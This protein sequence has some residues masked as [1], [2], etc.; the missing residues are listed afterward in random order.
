MTMPLWSP[1]ANAK[2]TTQLGQFWQ[3]IEQQHQVSLPTYRALHQWTV[4]QKEAFWQAVMAFADIRYEGSP[5]PALVEHELFQHNQW[6]PEV[7]LN[8]AENLLWRRDEHPALIS[9]TENTGRVAYSYA[10]LYQAAAA[11][12]NAHLSAGVKPGDRVAAWLPNGPEAII[13]ALGAA[14]V[15]AVWSSCSPDFGYAG[16]VDRFGQIKPTVLIVTDGY[17]YSGRWQ[18]ISTR[19]QEVQAALQVPVL[20][21]VPGQ[22]GSAT[23]NGAKLW[24]HWLDYDT[25][26]PAFVRQGFSAPHAILYS[27]GTTGQPKCIVH[28]AGGV[29]LQHA[30]EHRLHGDLSKKD[31]LFYFTTCG[32]MMWNWLL[33]GLQS[34]ATLVLYDGNPAYPD[35]GALFKLVEAENITHFGTSA[36]FVQALEQSDFYPQQEADVSS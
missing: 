8:Y 22:Q 34:G 15:G 32:W 18:D 5:T 35:L 4:E 16:V 11:V 17:S 3:Q 20:I 31:V 13:A 26:A 33:G 23:I 24:Q 21:Q 27:S 9:Y 19:V 30:K 28:G 1:T 14:W 10:Q 2:Q 36:R 12:A 29:L 25:P 6:F 7:R